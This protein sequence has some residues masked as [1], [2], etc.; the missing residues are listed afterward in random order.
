MVKYKF[1]QTILNHFTEVAL[2]NYN[3]DGH[4]ETLALA[5]GKKEHDIL[6]VTE[7]IFPSQNGASDFVEDKGKNVS[8]YSLQIHNIFS[9]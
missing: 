3:E 4:I 2:E 9:F 1:P 7:L 8:N 5:L 6:E